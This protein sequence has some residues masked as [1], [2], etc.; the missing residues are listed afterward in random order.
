MTKPAT[1]TKIPVSARALIGRINR[2]LRHDGET[3]KA[4]RG[5]RARRDLGDFYVLNVDKNMIVTTHV[6]PER[7]G[8]EIEALAPWETVVDTAT[9]ATV[10]G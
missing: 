9:D 4:L 3:L 8:R 2:K 1:K 10:R 5:E 7:L 6:D